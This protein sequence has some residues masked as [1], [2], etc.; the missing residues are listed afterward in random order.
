MA[1]G[2]TG[3]P[4]RRALKR[5]GLVDVWHDRRIPPGGLLNEEID[6]NLGDSDL[7]LF[8]IS[9][10]FINSEYCFH[11]EYQEAVKRRAAGETEIVPII[12]RACDWDVGG[13]RR[14]NA[15]P[16]D[17][18]LV[19]Q[20]AHSKADKHQRDSAWLKIIDGIKTVLDQIKKKA[21]PPKLLS[22]Y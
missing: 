2:R 9:A 13:L 22:D 12:I 17:G 15:L 4:F 16:R 1:E 18:V 20:D 5:N 3:F 6:A 8:L 19:T 10:D 7:C 11:K 21:Q 14:F